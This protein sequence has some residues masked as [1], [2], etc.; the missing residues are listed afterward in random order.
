[1]NPSVVLGATGGQGGAVVDA[2]LAAGLP[3]RAV[4]RDPGSH[5]ESK[6]RVEEQLIASGLAHTIVGP[7]YFFDNLLG[8]DDL[9]RGEI[10][11]A[12]RPERPLQQLARRDLG[13]FVAAVFADPARHTGLRIDVACD[14][15]T[16]QEMAT[17]VGGIVGRT[18][19]ARN[20]PVATIRAPDMRAK[21]GYLE[22]TGYHG[23]LEALR[24]DYPSVG[25]QSFDQWAKEAL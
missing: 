8:G 20:Y 14:D 1:M 2:L 21:F 3:V 25:W 19:A 15:P 17:T 11:L 6:R 5:F 7:T 4:V 16:P 10:E 13:R 23:D 24:R 9:E 18:V 12:V 22:Q